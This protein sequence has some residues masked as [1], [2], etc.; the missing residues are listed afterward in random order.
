MPVGSYHH[1]AYFC[2]TCVKIEID[3]KYAETA[4]KLHFEV[5]E[6]VLP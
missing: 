3:V 1:K 4:V 6:M 5:R 2:C